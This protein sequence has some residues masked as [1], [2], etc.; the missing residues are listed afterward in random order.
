MTHGKA[1][2]ALSDFFSCRFVLFVVKNQ[3][4]R[5]RCQPSRVAGLTMLTTSSSRVPRATALIDGFLRWTSVKIILFPVAFQTIPQGL[6][7]LPEI[8]NLPLLLFLDI[9]MTQP[10]SY[11]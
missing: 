10:P 4:H 11:P 3:V 5:W 2:N 1:A 6:V 8:V 9:Q 7:L